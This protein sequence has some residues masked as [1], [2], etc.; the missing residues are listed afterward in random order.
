MFQAV[1]AL[2]DAADIEPHESPPSLLYNQGWMLILILNWFHTHEVLGHPLA[3]HPE[4]T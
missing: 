1:H 4:A 2:I 3:F